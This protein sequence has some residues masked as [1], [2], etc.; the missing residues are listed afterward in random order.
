M[1]EKEAR[2]QVVEAG[3]QLLEQGLV[4]RTWGNVSCR[5]D[6]EHF[7]ITPSGLDYNRTGEEDLVLYDRGT[8]SFKGV[9]KPS[10]EKGI[11]ACAYELFPGVQFVIHTHQTY[12]SA[13]GLAGAMDMDLT[14]EE[15]VRLGGIAVADYGLPG[16]KKL[17]NAVANAM[18]TGAHTV[19]LAHHGVVICGCDKQDAYEKA[20]LLEEICKRNCKGQPEEEIMCEKTAMTQ[21]SKQLAQCDFEWK[22]VQTAPVLKAASVGPLTAQLDDM[23]QMMGRKVSVVPANGVLGALQKYPAVLV[24]GVG[25]VVRGQDDGDTHAMAL[26]MEKACICALHTGAWKKEKSL[27]RLDCML[28]HYIYQKKYSKKKNA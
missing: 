5:I 23:A 27:G 9:R 8:G 19:F 24:A 21:L 18:K 10:S 1:Q 4:A 3:R 14:E 6:E 26:L 7:L 16:T 15:K 17:K 12:A 28:M 13:L 20:A 11:H 22:L 25:A 2:R